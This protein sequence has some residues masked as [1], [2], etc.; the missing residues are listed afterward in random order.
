VYRDTNINVGTHCA[1]HRGQDNDDILAAIQACR[2]LTFE[3][4]LAYIA[5]TRKR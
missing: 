1:P 5:R 4:A 2:K 3:A